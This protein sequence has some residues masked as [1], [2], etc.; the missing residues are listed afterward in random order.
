MHLEVDHFK[1]SGSTNIDLIQQKNQIPVGSLHV[2]TKSATA[3]FVF[4]L[5]VSKETTVN[6]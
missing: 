5:F 2:G 4:C 1:H 6:K 3:T